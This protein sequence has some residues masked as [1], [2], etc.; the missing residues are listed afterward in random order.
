MLKQHL[1]VPED[2]L[3]SRDRLLLNEE[4]KE[5]FQ[6]RLQCLQI[7][8]TGITPRDEHEQFVALETPRLHGEL[9]ETGSEP[10]AR[11]L[12]VCAVLLY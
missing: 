5:L 2:R 8:C 9:G 4:L 10:Y 1:G 7:L 12:L 3:C 6:G 11:L